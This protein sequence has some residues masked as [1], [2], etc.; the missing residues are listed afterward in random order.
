MRMILI[1]LAAVV[2][3]G[4]A[5]PTVKP[6]WSVPN[7]EIEKAPVIHDGIV[8]VQPRE[9]NQAHLSA[10]ALK[11]GKQ[12]WTSKFP[13]DE[14]VVIVGTRLVV[15]D[16][17]GLLHSLDTK[18]GAEI[19]NPEM[20]PI[21]SATAD[22]NM[23]YTILKD[24]SVVAFDGPGHVLW[25]ASVP[26]SVLFH[27][28][29]AG[30]NVYIYGQLHDAKG[31]KNG[32]A[33]HAFDAK[34]GSLRWKFETQDCSGTEDIPFSPLAADADAAYIRIDAA[35]VSGKAGGVIAVDAA[36]GKQKWTS[37]TVQFQ[38]GAP[39]LFDGSTLVI[40][41]KPSVLRGL[42]RSTGQMKWE[43][44]TASTYNNWTTSDGLLFVADRK[45]HALIG[46][47]NATSPDSFLTVADIRTGKEL[48]RSETITLGTFTT[49]AV[50]DGIVVVGSLPFGDQSATG[51]GLFAFRATRAGK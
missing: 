51:S 22:G 15:T 46:T 1:I 5:A 29:V 11:T 33:I 7:L 43:S 25:K 4:C 19:G 37:P 14:I 24:R 2:L 45:A 44:P 8:Y 13:T 40:A 38:P 35:T 28:L 31:L 34:T 39:I 16:D 27:P 10:F 30:G 49:P 26:M 21:L 36:T 9:A 42:D 12:L 18:T 50:A 23:V 47:G 6:L 48:W 32:C 41:D 17:K 3:G 20:S